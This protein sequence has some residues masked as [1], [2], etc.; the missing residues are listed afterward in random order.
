MLTARMA[1]ES[2]IWTRDR[3]RSWCFYM[4]Q[5]QARVAIVISRAITDI[6]WMPVIAVL[7]RIILVMA[8]QTSPTTLITPCRFLS[9]ASSKRLTW[10][11]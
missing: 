9:S 3:A 11:A 8:F 6:W 2:I 7:F 10:L 5:A 4:A 1:T